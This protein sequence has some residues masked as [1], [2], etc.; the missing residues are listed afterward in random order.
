MRSELGA[1]SES[2]GSVTHMKGDMRLGAQGK[3]QSQDFEKGRQPTDSEVTG[4][5]AH[6]IPDGGFQAWKT[7][8]GA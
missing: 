1:D 5:T 8:L 7:V 4:L 2:K 3:D 6:L